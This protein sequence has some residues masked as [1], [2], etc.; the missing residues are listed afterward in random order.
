MFESS[1]CVRGKGSYSRTLRYIKNIIIDRSINLDKLFIDTY[2]F[3]GRILVKRVAHFLNQIAN[4]HM[5]L[6]ECN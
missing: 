3:T 2:F 6:G 4:M 1:F 5:A